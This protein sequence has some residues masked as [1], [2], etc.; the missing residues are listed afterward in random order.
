MGSSDLY[1]QAGV[2]IDTGNAAVSLMRAAV[3]STHGPRVLSSAG[4]FGGAY[5]LQGDTVLVA[6][7]D[8]VGTKVRLC[9]LLGRH[10]SAGVDLVN[11]CVNDVLTTGA[12]PLFFLDYFASSQVV[13][14]IVAKVVEGLA[15]ACREAGCALLGGETAELPGMYVPGE[16]DVAG[17][18]VGSVR[19]DML[20]DGSDI[21][22]GDVLIGLPSAGLHTNGFSLVHHVLSGGGSRTVSPE[23]LTTPDADL[24]AAPAD[25]LLGHH[26]S[27][28]HVVAP[29]L[30]ERL[31]KGIA[32]ITGGGL[33]ENLPRVLPEGLSVAID[34]SSWSPPAVFGWL[35]R[36]GKV[37]S[38]EMF[39][40]FNMGVGL[41][42]YAGGASADT[43]LDRV[44]SS[45]VLGQVSEGGE[46]RVRFDGT[47]DA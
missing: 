5:A 22:P 34:P 41:V 28:L 26:H 27:Y 44:P 37:S 43:I 14:D 25:L 18:I 8:S 13:P 20:L 32:H 24:G 38:E 47:T 2:D 33:I 3:E 10:S 7:A 23:M 35:Q 46:P 9:A 4:L 30:E 21:R 16:Y 6:S 1:R 12:L 11:H 45:W 19:R 39:R 36:R 42:L 17:F 31:I 40:V 15:S 29:L